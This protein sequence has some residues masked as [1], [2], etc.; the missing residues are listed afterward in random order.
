MT[1]TVDVGD[2]S[3]NLVERF[4][5]AKS[6]VESSPQ[7]CIPLLE[8]VQRDVQTL[9]L[10]SKNETM[11]DVS[12]KSIQFLTT[13]HFLAIALG[14]LPVEPGGAIIF[15]KNNILRSLTLWECFLEKLDILEILSKEETNELHSLLEFQQQ[16]EEQEVQLLGV[17]IDR[18]VKIARFK[19]KQ[20]Q[21]QEVD[22]LKALLDRRNRCGLSP[23]DDMDGHDLDSIERSLALMELHICKLEALENWSQSVRELPMIE[24][25]IKMDAERIKEKK[26]TG[27]DNNG[28]DD[29]NRERPTP[30]SGKGLQLTHITQNATTGELQFKRDEIRSKV[31]Q[32]GWAQPTMSL[33]ELGDRE[34]K[35]AMERG[36]RQKQAEAEQIHQPKR[37]DDLVRD[38]MED[39]HEL[40]E[41]SAELDRKWDDWKD[42]NPRGSGNKHANRG[43]K[44]F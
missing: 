17:T 20:Q 27:N 44:N 4:S 2:G 30:G 42:Q 7:Q 23:E 32:P 40:V 6:M 29:A 22:K 13:E 1:D 14:N 12:T 35:E 34:Y 26:F 3:S 36:A 21:R 41:A 19:A 38:G 33:E 24:R 18:D 37:Y 11:E 10:F 39:N 9:G 28:S 16:L 15:R 31:F 8:S 5:R 25:M 43:D